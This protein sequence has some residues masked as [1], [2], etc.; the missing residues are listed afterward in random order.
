MCRWKYAVADLNSANPRSPVMVA[1]ACHQLSCRESMMKREILA[2]PR[3]GSLDQSPCVVSF[4]VVRL[5]SA[6]QSVFT[7]HNAAKRM[8]LTFQTLVLDWTTFALVEF[9]ARSG[10]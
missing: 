4:W 3:A 7:F 6:S 9:W 2:S 1:A 5:N 10:P 8:P